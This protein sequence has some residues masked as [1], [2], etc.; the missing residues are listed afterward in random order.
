MIDNAKP[1]RNSR[2]RRNA[3]V[4]IGTMMLILFGYGLVRF[5]DAPLH[6]CVD[7]GYCGKQGQPHTQGELETFEIW[8][9]ALFLIWPIG[10]VVLYV[11][12]RDR[13]RQSGRK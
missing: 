11:L 2:W 8:Q 5:P 13:I 4:V 9:N 1:V 6:T 10:M 7:H 3:S 12:N